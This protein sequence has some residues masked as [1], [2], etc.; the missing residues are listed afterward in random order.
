MVAYP[1]C[2]ST[3]L[4]SEHPD[5]CFELFH[6]RPEHLL[7]QILKTKIYFNVQIHKL[8]AVKKRVDTIIFNRLQ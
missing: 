8:Y 6:C 7:T 5:H 2:W 1:S 3:G 4:Q